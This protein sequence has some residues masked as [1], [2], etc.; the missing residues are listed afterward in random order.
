MEHPLA[1]C[2]PAQA[3]LLLTDLGHLPVWGDEAASLQRA[4]LAADGRTA[5]TRCL[6]GIGRPLDSS[7]TLTLSSAPTRVEAAEG[8]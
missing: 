2:L 6:P 7:P 4:T 8:R 5:A 3:A 1:V